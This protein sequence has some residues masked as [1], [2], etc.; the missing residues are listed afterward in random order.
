MSSLVKKILIVDDDPDFVEGLRSFL[1]THGFRVLTAADGRQGLRMAKTEAPD[2]ILMDVMMKERT[3]GFFVV[4]E[5][6]RTAGLER[7]P[8]FV[9]SGL[10][11]SPTEFGISPDREWLA[12][13]ELFTKPLDLDRLL[14]AIDRHVGTAGGVASGTASREEVAP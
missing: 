8:V 1:E 13:D 9:V 12:H 3:E 7:V 6:R 4:Q 2:L 14:A 10:Y 5:I 11:S